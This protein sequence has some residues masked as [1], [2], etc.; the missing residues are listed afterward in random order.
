MLDLI[1]GWSVGLGYT[2]HGYIGNP[3]GHLVAIL[4]D[5]RIMVDASIDQASRPLREIVMPPVVVAHVGEEFV[6]GTATAGFKYNGCRVVYK[7]EPTNQSYR[8]STNWTKLKETR[9]ATAALIK[10]IMEE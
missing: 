3:V 7:P 5:E 6:E 10:L 1:G 8:Q 4:P 2:P 9:R